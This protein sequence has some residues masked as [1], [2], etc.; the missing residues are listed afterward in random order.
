MR[1]RTTR[2]EMAEKSLRSERGGGREKQGERE[3]A[4]E[5]CFVWGLLCGSSK[6]FPA[7]ITY[8]YVL[9]WSLISST[10]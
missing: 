3:R 6:I 4:T 1:K 8:T 5:I 9:F 7:K 10:A 2:R